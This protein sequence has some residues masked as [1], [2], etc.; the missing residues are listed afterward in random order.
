MLG[1]VEV[2]STGDEEEG[3]DALD[4]T[5]GGVDTTGPCKDLPETTRMS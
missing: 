1:E 2:T 3:E 5:D 4:C